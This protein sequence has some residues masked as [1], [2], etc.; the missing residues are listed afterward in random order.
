MAIN[1]AEEK[2]GTATTHTL[3][4]RASESGTDRMKR[5]ISIDLFVQTNKNMRAVLLHEINLPIEQEHERA[6]EAEQNVCLCRPDSKT[7]RAEWSVK[8]DIVSLRTVEYCIIAKNSSSSF[9]LPGNIILVIITYVVICAKNRFSRCLVRFCSRTIL[10]YTYVSFLRCYFFLC[11]IFS[12]C[13]FAYYGFLF[14][15]SRR[16]RHRSSIR[17]HCI[18]YVC[19]C[20]K[21]RMQKSQS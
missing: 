18:F 19:V 16:R 3:R 1:A 12:S 4:E 7:H 2:Q 10:Q 5:E 15:S 8:R 6:S 17:I 14:S 9:S 11:R 13:T 20:V 21:A